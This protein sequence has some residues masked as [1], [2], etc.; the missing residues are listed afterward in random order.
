MD[1][2]RSRV[3]MPVSHL[4]ECGTSSFTLLLVR[5]PKELGREIMADK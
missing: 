2:G 5:L 1:S 4:L 3:V